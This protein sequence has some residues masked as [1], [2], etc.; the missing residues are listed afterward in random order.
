MP[1][2]LLLATLATC[3]SWKPA[4]LISVIGN[5]ARCSR[6]KMSRWVSIATYVRAYA[7]HVHAMHGHAM[8]AP[9]VWA[10][11]LSP[12]LPTGPIPNDCLLLT[13]DY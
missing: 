5:L 4:R 3:A 7:M 6:W 2:Y 12:D 8:H 1:S 9:L 10:C 13:A 11:I